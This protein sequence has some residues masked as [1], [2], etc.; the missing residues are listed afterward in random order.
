MEE[1]QTVQTTDNTQTKNEQTNQQNQAE[2][3]QKPN[4]KGKTIP[5]KKNH[6]SVEMD[7]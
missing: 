5:Q 4:P 6:Q 3:K 1:N 7:G 2:N